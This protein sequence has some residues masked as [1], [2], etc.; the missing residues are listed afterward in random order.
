MPV[1][2]RLLAW[3]SLCICMSAQAADLSSLEAQKI[4][5]LIASVAS[6][7]G[8][9]F[10]RND[11]SYEAKAAAD[12]LRQK[13]RL[14]GSRVKS[15]IDFIRDCGSVSSVTGKPYLIRFAD[16]R[17]VTAEAFLTARLKEYEARA[18]KGV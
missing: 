17:Q 10:I 1:L 18:G 14:A 5:Y 3:L 7:T 9:Q 16:G 8:A 6:L 2:A 15:A 11:T 13:L 4:D 12:H